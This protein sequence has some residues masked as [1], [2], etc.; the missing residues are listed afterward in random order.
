SVSHRH[1]R[2]PAFSPPVIL[3]VEALRPLP[4]HSSLPERKLSMTTN[5]HPD[6]FPTLP[7]PHSCMVNLNHS[8]IIPSKMRGI[9]TLSQLYQYRLSV[10][11]PGA[12]P[13]CCVRGISFRKKVATTVAPQK[14]ST[15]MR[16][17][18][19][20]KASE[21]LSAANTWSSSCCV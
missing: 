20:A 5:M 7:S 6:P 8:K 2:K 19:M 14:T 12:S 4:L 1:V 15:A 10:F 11:S 16:P 9:C 13:D 18:W 3:L 17:C 21:S